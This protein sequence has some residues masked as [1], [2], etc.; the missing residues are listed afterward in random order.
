MMT[1][2]V[3]DGVYRLSPQSE[4]SQCLAI[5]QNTTSTDVQLYTGDCNNAYEK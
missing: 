2:V 5:S 3:V 1:H 4:P